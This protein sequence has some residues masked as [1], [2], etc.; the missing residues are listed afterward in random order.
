ML[1]FLSFSACTEA[2]VWRRRMRASQRFVRTTDE[3]RQ[4]LSFGCIEDDSF[5]DNV[6]YML[7]RLKMFVADKCERTCPIYILFKGP[8]RM[9]GQL[10]G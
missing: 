2:N 10:R 9:D 5:S 7:L 1:F 6:V 3:D 8:V 4:R